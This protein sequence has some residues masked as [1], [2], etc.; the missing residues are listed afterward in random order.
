MF[1]NYINNTNNN[2]NS[3]FLSYHEVK[4]SAAVASY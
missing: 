4:N 3:T 1:K 2:N